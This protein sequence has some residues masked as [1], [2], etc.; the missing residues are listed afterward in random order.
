MA[1]FILLAQLIAILLHYP[2]TVVLMGLV[3]WY[4][5]LELVCRPCKVMTETVGP[6]EGTRWEVWVSFYP[7]ISEMSLKTLQ[8]CLGL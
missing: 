4:D 2:C 3:D 5:F 1:Y 7:C 6:M 8:A